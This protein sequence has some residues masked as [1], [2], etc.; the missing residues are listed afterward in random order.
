MSRNGDAVTCPECGTEIGV[1]V[2][3]HVMSC[4]GVGNIPCY[5]QKIDYRK[6]AHISFGVGIICKKCAKKY[7]PEG[8]AYRVTVAYGNGRITPFIGIKKRG[9]FATRKE[10]EE[11]AKDMGRRRADNFP[12]VEEVK[13]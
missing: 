12:T 1:L 3:D 4:P 5:D 2:L 10:A 8:I 9:L 7:F 13:Y 6:A 11:A